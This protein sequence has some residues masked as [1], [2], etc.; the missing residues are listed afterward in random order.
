MYKD[1][2]DSLNSLVYKTNIILKSKL[3][4]ALKGFDITSE[5]WVMLNRL[6]QKEGYNQKEL[7]TESFKEQAAITRT[8]DLLEKK[9]LIER[10]KSPSDRR[11]YLIFVT[12]KGKTLLEDSIPN[13]IMY[14]NM[15]NSILSEEETDELKALLRKLCE[16]LLSG[17]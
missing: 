16:G 15:L 14:R 11:E 5:Q 2:N 9:A 3:Q 7:A 6:Y 13:A 4:I 1:I 10:K 8:L 12:T 17:T